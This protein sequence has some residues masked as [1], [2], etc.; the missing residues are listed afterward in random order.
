M[1]TSKSVSISCELSGFADSLHLSPSSGPSRSLVSKELNSCWG[2][3][4]DLAKKTSSSHLAV[5]LGEGVLMDMPGNCG[6]C[7]T[8]THVLSAL[9]PA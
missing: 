9:C 3:N 5:V 6:S 1:G 2:P 4:S 7:T 8:S